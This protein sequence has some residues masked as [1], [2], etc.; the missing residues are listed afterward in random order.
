MSWFA[1]E[2]GITTAQ[3]EEEEEEAEDFCAA[4]QAETETDGP[5]GRP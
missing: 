3:Q 2:R 5:S 4:H 1:R